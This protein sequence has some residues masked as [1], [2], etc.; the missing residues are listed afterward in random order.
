MDNWS[1]S[2]ALPVAMLGLK[3][4]GGRVFDRLGVDMLKRHRAVSSSSS[5]HPERDVDCVLAVMR[6]FRGLVRTGEEAGW[7]KGDVAASLLTLASIH[8]SKPPEYAGFRH[9]LPVD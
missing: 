7:S 8:E 1:Q 6:A 4:V 3:G 5:V 2:Q 9:Q